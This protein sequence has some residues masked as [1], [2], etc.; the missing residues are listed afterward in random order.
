MSTSAVTTAPTNKINWR[1]VLGCGLLAG[2][3]WIILGTIVTAVLA[4]DF[5]ALPNNRLGAPTPGFIVLNIVFDLLTG[6]SILW[7]YAA[8]RPRYGAGAKTATIAAF[9]S[10]FIVSLEDAI[11]CSFELFP[12]RTIIPLLFGTLP[13]LIIATLVG[14]K[15][16]KE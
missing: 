3:V 7:L 15:F 1:R 16:Y 14:A 11:W 10:W 13:A 9:A 5:I 4:R 8:I 2:V 12:A 6:I